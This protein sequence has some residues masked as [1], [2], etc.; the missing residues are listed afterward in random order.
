M[1]EVKPTIKKVKHAERIYKNGP[2][3]AGRYNST[4]TR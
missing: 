4:T 2:V 3:Q 1:P